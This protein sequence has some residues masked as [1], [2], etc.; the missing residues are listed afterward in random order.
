MFLCDDLNDNNDMN[1]QL[2]SLYARADTAIYTKATFNQLKVAY[3]TVYRR[4]L[5]CTRRDGAS[6]M[7]VTNG[8]DSFETLCRKYIY[9]FM[10][11]FE[12]S[13]N[14]IINHMYENYLVLGGAM[15]SIW[16]KCL[17]T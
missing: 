8:I 5:G 14:V 16:Q 9:K 12:Y 3:N 6:M 1:R 11:H 2:R 10:K 15:H 7:L 4:L 13:S 17:Y